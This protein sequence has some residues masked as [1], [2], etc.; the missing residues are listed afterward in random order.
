MW[1]LLIFLCCSSFAFSQGK[2]DNELLWE[3]S[4][5]GLKKKSYLFGSLHSNDK[6][7]FRLSDSTYVVMNKVDMIVV[8]TDVF[9]LFDE[10]DT[11]KED[12]QLLF[13]NKGNPYTSSK[14]PTTTVYGNEDGMPQ[15]LDA[16]F[17]EYC[18]NANK[19]FFALESVKEQLSMISDYGKAEAR[20]G[21]N[22]FSVSQEKMIEFYLKGDINSLDRLMRANL[23]LQKGM[24]EDLIVKRNKKMVQSIDSLIRL[25][26]CLSVIGAGHL[27]GD[28][29]II[30]LLRKKGYKLR[31]VESNFSD[32]AIP[33]KVAVREKRNYTYVNDSIGFVAVFPGKPLEKTIY[34]DHPYLI[35]REMGQGNTY[36]IEIV[37]IDNSLTLLQQATIY[38]ATPNAGKF[39]CYTLD[40]GTEVC[41][42]L[43]DTYPEG[44]HFVRVMQN[45]QY[46]LILKAYGGNKFMNSNRPIHFFGKVWFE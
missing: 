9:S 5:N 33:E 16:Y 7:L 23:S 41:E 21:I 19:K 2:I 46:L 25:Q 6:R 38:I 20:L 43:S 29:G 14:K 37:P 24:Y 32:K 4:G 13:D 35:Y 15:F 3:I 11:R 39:R 36:S 26:S 31:R 28:E 17:Q 22:P 18:F 40:E 44:M 12:V 10:W 45:D 27:A 8:E 42:G 34:E 1:K 30:S